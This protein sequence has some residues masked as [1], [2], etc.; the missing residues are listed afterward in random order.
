MDKC[1][2]NWVFLSHKGG[3]AFVCS[4][5]AWNSH[6]DSMGVRGCGIGL[7]Q[8]LSIVDCHSQ[9]LLDMQQIALY[10]SSAASLNLEG[11]V[12]GRIGK[13]LVWNNSR[14]GAGGCMCVLFIL[15][16]SFAG[17]AF[18][19]WCCSATSSLLCFMLMHFHCPS[20]M[21]CTMLDNTSCATHAL[22]TC[23][24]RLL[25]NVSCICKFGQTATVSHYS[26]AT[27][28]SIKNM[29]KGGYTSMMTSRRSVL[30][31]VRLQLGA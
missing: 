20:R 15:G 4:N 10:S 9:C 6:L 25:L 2:I 13:G 21:C 18:E 23:Q 1:W 12:I 31:Q 19:A 29:G 27:K 26:H 11:L 5:S 7:R 28:F 8:R 14:Q 30:T 17:C 24:T 16:G 22:R 3:G